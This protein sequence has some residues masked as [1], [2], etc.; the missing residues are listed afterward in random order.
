MSIKYSTNLTTP[1]CIF[2]GLRGHEVK[3]LNFYVNM[4]RV[5]IFDR[6][7][8]FIVFYMIICNI[9]L[10]IHN[11]YYTIKSIVIQYKCI[12]NVI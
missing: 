1:D 4:I 10:Y 9:V 11:I 8:I 5:Y 6:Y 3:Q 12:H 7:K 2:I